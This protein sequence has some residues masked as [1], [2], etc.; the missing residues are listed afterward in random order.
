LIE[1]LKLLYHRRWVRK[2]GEIFLNL[3]YAI[4]RKLVFWG[5]ANEIE[6]IDQFQVHS[7]HPQFGKI[8]DFVAESQI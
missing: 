2:E 8:M 3:K 4:C 1:G 6:K 5:L 7:R